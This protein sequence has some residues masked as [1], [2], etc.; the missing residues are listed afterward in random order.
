MVESHDLKKHLN[1]FSQEITVLSKKNKIKIKELSRFMTYILGH[2]PWEF[3]LV[4]DREGFI[5]FKTLL[6]AIHEESGWGYVKQAS[7]NEVLMSQDRHLFETDEKR[8][9]ATQKRWELDLHTPVRILPSLLFTGIRKKA[10]AT[11]IEN[12]LRLIEEKYHILS[13]DRDMAT[14]IGKRLDQHPVI[15][16]ILADRAQKEGG[17]L[18]SFGKL[19]ISPE[20][21]P[22]HIAGPPVPKN[23]LKAREE[24]AAKKEEP[25]ADF[26][27]GTFFLDAD[28]DMDQF[29]RQKDKRRGKKKGWKEEARKMRR[30]NHS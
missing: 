6:Q 7:I 8:I 10:H 4:P 22:R 16:E 29:R 17:K 24:K 12:G 15:L 14:R 20:I 9:R 28:R 23:V 1:H 3:G 27:A 5:R 19:F 13:P 21:N 18:Y 26:S 11:V 2:A 30:K 25:L